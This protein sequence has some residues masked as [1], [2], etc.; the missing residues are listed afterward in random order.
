[1]NAV[2]DSKILN[3]LIYK[4]PSSM[5]SLR[6]LIS[7][8]PTLTSTCINTSLCITPANPTSLHE[9]SFYKIQKQK[10]FLKRKFFTAFETGS[11]HEQC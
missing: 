1:M 3:I 7:F 11:L 2:K 9:V 8:K 6:K 10:T 5:F 4:K